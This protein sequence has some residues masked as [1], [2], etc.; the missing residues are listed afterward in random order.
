MPS[1]GGHLDSMREICG[2]EVASKVGPVWGMD[3]E[4][5]LQGVFRHSGHD[6]L[7]FGMGMCVSLLWATS[8]DCF[9]GR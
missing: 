2:D 6:G 5:Q 3:E 1:S 7:W 8:V 9:L 4:G